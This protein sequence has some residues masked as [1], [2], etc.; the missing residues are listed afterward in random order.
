MIT[1]DHKVLDEEQESRL[2][3]RYA[4]VVQDLTTQWIQ[5]YPSKTKSAQDTQRSLRKFLRPEENPGS[6]HTDNSLEFIKACEK[7]DWNHERSTPQRSETH[8]IAERA[9]RRVKEGTSSVLVQSGLRDSWWA[10][11]M[12]YCCYLR[13]VQDPQADGQTPHH[14]VGR[15]FFLEQK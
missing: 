10:E 9:V 6:T 1:A 13:N 15:S 5:S 14:L 4:V 8:G 3:Q 7:L 2:H 11:A 12:E